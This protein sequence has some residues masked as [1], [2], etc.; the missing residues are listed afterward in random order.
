VFEY[1]T[2][3]FFEPQNIVEACWF[4]GF[5]TQFCEVFECQKFRHAE[6]LMLELASLCLSTQSVILLRLN[7]ASAATYVFKGDF[8]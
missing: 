6:F 5:S 4:E 8:L 2:R 3:D 7:L 1:S